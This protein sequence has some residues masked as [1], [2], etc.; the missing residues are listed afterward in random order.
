MVM[1]CG[2]VD[3]F[4]PFYYVFP[5]ST[6]ENHLSTSVSNY[7]F[8]VTNYLRHLSTFLLS[9]CKYNKFISFLLLFLWKTAFLVVNNLPF[10]HT[11]HCLC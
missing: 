3:K 1:G 7:Y 10:M 11:S 9:S 2:Y 4:F 6:H 8:L 5:L